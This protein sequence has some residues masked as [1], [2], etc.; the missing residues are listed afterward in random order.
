MMKK[1]W[2][3]IPAVI[4]TIFA[5]SSY[6]EAHCEIPCGIYDD[7]MRLEMITEHIATVEKSVN[8]IKDLSDD[9]DKNH[10]QLVR[11]IDNKEHHAS[12]IQHIVSQYFLTQRIKPDDQHY[13]KKLGTLHRMLVYA[14]KCKQ[15]LDPANI[16]E[17]RK[18]T[19]E[20]KKL[21]MSKE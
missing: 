18:A 15:S 10:N 11:W 6:S 2:L 13:E 17:L 14:M 8:Q 1:L 3:A 5:C 21:Y 7:Q 19:R 20:F 9:K 4:I 16:E 12:E